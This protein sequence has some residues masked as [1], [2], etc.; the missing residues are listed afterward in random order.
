MT[1]V[2]ATLEDRP[3]P[4]AAEANVTNMAYEAIRRDLLICQLAPGAR[5]SVLG[6]SK[7]LRASQS[8]IREALSRLTAEGLVTLEP[9][10]GFI[11][12]PISVGRFASLSKART[13]I[14]A[15]CLRDSIAASDVEFEV[16]LVAASHRVLRRLEQMDGSEAAI[17]QYVGAHARF[18]EALVSRCSNPWLLWMRGLLFAQ[19]VRYRN[20]CVPFAR[21]KSDFYSAEGPFLRAVFRKD[22][23]AAENLLIKQYERVCALI[24][25]RLTELLPD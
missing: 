13:A 24:S 19:S 23:D 11:V 17:A 1:N 10:R 2:A 20:F 14:D 9:N 6:L 7:A 5:V 25:A 16:E 12:T 21:D 3:G 4:P 22:S 8:A 18:H 15:L